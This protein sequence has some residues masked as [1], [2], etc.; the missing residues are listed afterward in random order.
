MSE[1]DEEIV[2]DTAEE[3]YTHRTKDNEEILTVETK[4]EEEEEE[5][6]EDQKHIYTKRVAYAY[7]NKAFRDT[8]KA[9]FG[10]KFKSPKNG[11]ILE[12]HVYNSAIATARTRGLTLK[13]TDPEFQLVYASLAY[14]I[15]GSSIGIK[16]IIQH[17]KNGQ[18]EWK[19]PMYHNLVAA[20]EAE[21]ADHTKDVVEGIHECSDCKSKGR[22]YNKTRNV[23]IQTRGG[24]EG[25][26]VFVTCATCR[27]M[28]KQYN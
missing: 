16:D 25:M 3:E 11:E 23:Q 10:E 9:K 21:E 8:V 5:E 6:E 7:T 22:I 19:A 24:D 15:L 2:I 20:R 18:V 27:K 13:L 14:D 4:R 1:S 12:K 28:W 26:T 17:L